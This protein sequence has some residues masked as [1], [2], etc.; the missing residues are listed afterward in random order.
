MLKLKKL[1][2]KPKRI[3][4]PIIGAFVIGIIFG[5][6][7]SIVRDLPPAESIS[8]FTP[9]VATKVYDNKDSLIAEFFIERREL[10]SIDQVPKYLKDGLI[11]IE[12]RSF[13]KH[14]GID[15]LALIRSLAKNILHLK[16]EARAERG[17]PPC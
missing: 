16:A 17:L 1:F 5:V 9:P 3:L 10:T 4:L 7:I 12:D 11:C 2:S 6:Y 13:Y 14:W 15:V 8:F